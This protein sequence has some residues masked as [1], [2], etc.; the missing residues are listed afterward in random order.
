MFEHKEGMLSTVIKNGHW[1][2]LC[3]IDKCTHNTNCKH[4]LKSLSIAL[5]QSKLLIKDK[6]VY[7]H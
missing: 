1:I 7:T 6:L 4:M 3:D 2:M 5:D